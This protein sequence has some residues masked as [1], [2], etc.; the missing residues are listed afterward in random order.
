MSIFVAEQFYAD[1]FFFLLFLSASSGQALAA[2][3]EVPEMPTMLI[4]HPE[5][6]EGDR[7]LGVN[8]PIKL[9]EIVRGYRIDRNTFGDFRRRL[10]KDPGNHKNF[11]VAAG[12]LERS[13]DFYGAKSAIKLAP[14]V[15]ESQGMHTLIVNYQRGN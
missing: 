4:L 13:N 9:A 6:R 14:T 15:G 10:K 1:F 2:H 7:I 12:S 11:H 5:I 3:L 8:P